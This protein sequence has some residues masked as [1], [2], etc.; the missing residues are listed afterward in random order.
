MNTRWILEFDYDA[1]P[2]ERIEGDL[3]DYLTATRGPV[4]VEGNRLVFS[5]GDDAMWAKIRFANHVLKVE[6][7]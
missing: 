3:S 1:D 6:V 5:H 4:V 2:D 7:Q